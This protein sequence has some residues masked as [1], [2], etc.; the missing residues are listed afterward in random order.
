MLSGALPDGKVAEEQEIQLVH[1][2]GWPDMGVPDDPVLAIRCVLL[3]QEQRNVV[4]HCSA[5][6][7]RTGTLL[8][9]ECSMRSLYSCEEV[10][11][12]NI[13]KRLREKRSLAVQ[14]KGQYLFLYKSLVFY[15]AK[16]VCMWS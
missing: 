11:V 2:F 5:G 6:I 12:Y 1:Y 3:M 8:A 7:G 16:C 13:V 15:C 10:S 14:T 9:L 4:Y